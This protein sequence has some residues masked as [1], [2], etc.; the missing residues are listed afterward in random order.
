VPRGDRSLLFY[1][2]VTR[3]TRS[4]VA[5]LI[6]VAVVLVALAIPAWSYLRAA[7]LVA[8]AAQMEGPWVAR[9]TAWDRRAFGVSDVAVPAR[10]GALRGRLYRPEGAVSRAV[11][12]VPGV[13]AEGIDEPRLDR[14][15]RDV[16]AAGLAVLTPELPDLLDYRITPRSPDDIEDAAR[17]LADRGDLAPDGRV[18]LVGISFSGGLAIVAA[19]RPA[20]SGRLAF[21]LSF[22]GHGDLSRTMR[23][24]ATGLLPDGRVYPPHDYGVVI[25]LLN[26]A[27]LLLPD[28]QVEPLREGIRTFLRASHLAMV[29]QERAERVFKAAIAFEETLPDPAA[30]YLEWVNTR[31][32]EALGP[33]LMPAVEQNAL[34]P[35]L[36]PERADPPAA[37]VFLLHGEDDNV[38]PAAEASEL[39]ASLRARGAEVDLLVSPLITHAEV[40]P[41]PPAGEV[42]RMVRF[43]RRVLAE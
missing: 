22:G 9:L 34:D 39:A 41:E 19:G 35:S 25:I 15:A 28:E 16:A 14:F 6:A 4:I 26:T 2:R 29:D 43:W 13:H 23:Y 27:H 38:I 12:L 1:P 18:G 17:W 8:R 7:A 33:L 20:L 42:W 32:V 3:P 36:S 40:D 30:T 11:V 31:N 5:V 10:R 37:P 21:V 24:L